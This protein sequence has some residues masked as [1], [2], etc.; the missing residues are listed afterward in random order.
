MPRHSSSSSRPIPPRPLGRHRAATQVVPDR[1]AV[2]ERPFTDPMLSCGLRC[3]PPSRGGSVVDA[4][5]GA[6]PSKRRVDPPSHPH[7]HPDHH[8]PRQ[9]AA[10]RGGCV[11]HRGRVQLLRAGLPDPKAALT[12]LD[13][14]QQ[15]IVFDRTG[16]VE[17]ARLGSLRREVVDVRPDPGRDARRD[18]R[19]RGQGLLD[20]PRLRPGSASSAPAS[21]RSPVVPAA[22]RRSPSSSS[23]TGCC[24]P[25]PSRTPPT[26]ASSARSS[27]RSA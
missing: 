22:P 7:R 6:G 27:S 13:F 21:T 26:T 23:A 25:R 9:R 18:D 20:Q 17:L 12:D 2:N 19:D 5:Q 16:K 11:V 4:P 24:P 3:R 1:E 10:G 15:T 8:R 14:D